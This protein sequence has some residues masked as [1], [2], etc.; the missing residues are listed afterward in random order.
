VLA[1]SIERAME[2]VRGQNP[3]KDCKM[4]F[5]MD[6][7]RVLVSFWCERASAG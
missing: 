4:K 1:R 2:I 7:E 3:G 6:P 5:P